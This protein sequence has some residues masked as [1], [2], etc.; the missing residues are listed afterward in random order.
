MV[1]HKEAVYRAS[2]SLVL[3]SDE[4]TALEQLAYEINSESVRV[5]STEPEVFHLRWVEHCIVE[6]HIADMRNDFRDQNPERIRP[7]YASRTLS[8]LNSNRP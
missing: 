8:F 7:W 1:A 5:T 2:V 3:A 6:P 4:G